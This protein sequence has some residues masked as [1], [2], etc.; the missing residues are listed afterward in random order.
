[1]PVVSDTSPISY[2]ILIGQ[3]DL[4]KH[5]YGDVRIPPAVY[6]ELQD[7]DGS[8]R[9][10]KWASRLPFWGTVE[11][12][13]WKAEVQD[14]LLRRLDA[15]ERAAIRL[16]SDLNS[17]LLL[18]DEVAGRRCAR[19]LNIPITGTLGVLDTAA[20]DGRIDV[21]SAIRDLQATSFRASESLYQWLRDRHHPPGDEPPAP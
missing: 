12:P 20:D 7:E 13:D 19:E 6:E 5:F 3:V 10:R 11:P 21:E 4:L 15:G 2:L 14:D 9:V 16:A 18:I 1:M 8:E 17:D